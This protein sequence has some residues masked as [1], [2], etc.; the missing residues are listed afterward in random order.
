[1]ATLA[2]LQ[3]DLAVA[4][5]TR[6]DML[7]GKVAQYEVSSGESGNRIVYRTLKEVND[8]IAVLKSEI[9]A[10]NTGGR[11]RLAVFRRPGS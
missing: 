1:M 2:E 9:A 8:A 4:E 5:Q 10:A 3:A 7:A 11:V 6:R